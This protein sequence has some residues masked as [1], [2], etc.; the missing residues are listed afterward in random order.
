MSS[1]GQQMGTPGVDGQASSNRIN[2]F[3]APRLL[4]AAEMAAANVIASCLETGEQAVDLSALGLIELS[5]DTLK[6]LHQLIRHV[7]NDLVQA[8]SEAEF[9]RLTASLRLFLFG[10]RLSSVPRELTKLSNMTVLSLRNNR[11]T[12]IPSGICRLPRLQELHVGQNDLRFLPWEMLG[13]LHCHGNH[14]KDFHRKVVTDPNPL[15]RPIGYRGLKGPSPLPNLSSTT[16]RE[17]VEELQAWGETTGAFFHKMKEWYSG[18]GV[19]W[20]MRHELELRLK[21]GRVRHNIHLTQLSDEGT[22]V[23]LCDEQL[24]YLAS[25][26]VRFFDV[27][28]S[29]TRTTDVPKTSKTDYFAVEDPLASA[30]PS[31]ATSKA[32]SLLELAFRSAQASSALNLLI[33]DLP[34]TLEH[35]VRQATQAIEYGNEP[36]HVCSKHYVIP[37]AEWV[38]YWFIGYPSQE[39]LTHDTVFPFMRR[40]CSWQCAQPSDVAAIGL[41]FG[42]VRGE[43]SKQNHSQLM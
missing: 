37:R 2:H 25:S 42:A 13:L 24:I 41:D 32:S 3:Q 17:Y 28:G 12:E 20:T 16:V 15:V 9:R 30:P 22:E 38:E 27:N 29:H 6:P 4:P 23:K 43:G 11:L 7:H 5:D 10:N 21:L 1:D 8:P 26:P 35:W 19:P 14:T 40:V 18:D 31:A 33:D 34:P 39:Q 36:C